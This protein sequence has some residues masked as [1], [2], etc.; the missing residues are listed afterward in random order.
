MPET[1]ALRYLGV[2]RGREN[3]RTLALVRDCARELEAA[4][5]PRWTAQALPLSFAAGGVSLGGLW[6][7]SE[8]LARRLCGCREAALFAVTLGPQPDLLLR[9]YAAVDM[10]R[11]AVL[12]ACAAAL[13][14]DLCDAC[15][16]ELDAEAAPRG[17]RTGRRYSP[18]YGDFP[19]ALQKALLARLDAPKRI[20]L[21]ATAAMALAPSKSVTAVAGLFPRALP[22]ERGP[23]CAGCADRACPYRKE[24]A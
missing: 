21:S 7:P 5:S 1:E 17:L 14:E 19:L 8:Q 18:G 11:A 23:A 12:Q 3:A 24:E 16:E 9:R 15:Q 4:A 22:Q 20:G 13:A 10:A 6:V 2:K